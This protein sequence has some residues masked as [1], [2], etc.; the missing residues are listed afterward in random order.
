[1]PLLFLIQDTSKINLR[2]GKKEIIQKMYLSS[3]N[4]TSI[5]NVL[6]NMS[7]CCSPEDKSTILKL[8]ALG[9]HTVI[10][11]SLSRAAGACGGLARNRRPGSNAGPCNQKPGREWWLTYRVPIQIP[12]YLNFKVPICLNSLRYMTK[13]WYTNETYNNLFL[14]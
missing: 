1:M 8:W 14:G 5:M 7:K 13:L 6:E 4:I 2:E 3:T 9:F 12:K 11:H 10:F